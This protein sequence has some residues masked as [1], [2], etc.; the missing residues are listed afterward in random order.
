MNRRRL[1][2]L[3]G[4][5]LIGFSGCVGDDEAPEDEVTPTPA[6]DATPTPEDETPTPEEI[7][8]ETPTPEEVDEVTPTPEEENGYVD[9]MDDQV[10]LG[11]GETAHLSNGVEVTAHEFE[12]DTQVGDFTEA[13]DGYHFALLYL[14]GENTS[15]DPE[16]L[17]QPWLDFVVLANGNQWDAE[18]GIGMDDYEAFEGGEV[19]PGVT[20][21]GYVAFEVPEDLEQ[22]DLD[23]VW[24]DDFLGA[25]I[26]VRW[27][28]E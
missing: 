7:D 12:F 3:T 4:I 27:T 9:E 8:D 17:P 6:D 28:H 2:G 14:T 20:R 11:Y 21:E 15:D 1:L 24:H 26:N 13:D 16:H 25:N 19:Q 5:A 22:E 10:V 18:S 23:T